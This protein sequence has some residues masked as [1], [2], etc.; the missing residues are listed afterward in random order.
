MDADSIHRSLG[1][2]EGAQQQILDI[3]RDRKAVVDDHET[4]IRKLEKGQW[5]RLGAL[6]AITAIGSVALT[7]L[8]DIWN[9][10]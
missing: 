3:L 1:R 9:Q 6:A 4:R 10:L 8:K 7:L 2:L 5:K